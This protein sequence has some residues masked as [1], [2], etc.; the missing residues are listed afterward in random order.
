MTEPRQDRE[1][2]RPLVADTPIADTPFADGVAAAELR[3][4]Q[5]SAPDRQRLV[6]ADSV[7]TG[8]SG[9]G[10]D[11]PSPTGSVAGTISYRRSMFR[12]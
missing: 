4:P 11:L 12:R 7:R 5:P 2:A 10:S 3:G 9:E 6:A 8:R 1:R